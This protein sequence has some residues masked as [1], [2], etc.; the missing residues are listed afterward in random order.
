MPL[1]LPAIR[2]TI[3]IV[4]GESAQEADEDGRARIIRKDEKGGDKFVFLLP[5]EGDAGVAFLGVQQGFVRG[6]GLEEE[7]DLPAY[8]TAGA[9][10]LGEDNVDLIELL[11]EGAYIHSIQFDGVGYG[12]GEFDQGFGDGDLYD[13]IVVQEVFEAVDL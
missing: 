3:Y 10:L 4:R 13:V 6:R 9:V 8:H 12:W 2:Q 7:G 1:T 11:G 5:V